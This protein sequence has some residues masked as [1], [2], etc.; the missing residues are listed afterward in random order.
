M[1][2]EEWLASDELG[3]MLAYL[4]GDR[5]P[6]REEIVARD[7]APEKCSNRKIALFVLSVCQR[8]QHSPINEPTL[9]GIALLQR[10]S[11]GEIP[12]SELVRSL[13]VICQDEVRTSGPYFPFS[14]KRV[15]EPQAA[16]WIAI[17]TA[18]VT[19]WTV[20][21]SAI[22]RDDANGYERMGLK[23]RSHERTESEWREAYRLEELC[24]T[25]LLRDIVGNPF[26]PVA[27]DAAWRTDTAVSLAKGMYESR[28]FG[29][30]PILADALQDAGCTSD[31]VLNHCRDA[32][33]VHVRGCW[34]VDLVL[35]KS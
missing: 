30:V 22:K 2:E 10:F 21:E 1:T 33:Q 16:H 9:Q 13:E 11:E 25:A 24:Q 6:E 20:A 34:V 19:A 5:D 26:R 8:V 27:F 4:R 29:A 17:K 31:D 12:L 7:G 28:D 32:K 18:I 15:G 23:W 14:S 3:P 35:G